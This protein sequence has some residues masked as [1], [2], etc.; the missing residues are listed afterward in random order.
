[1]RAIFFWKTLGFLA[2][3]R[4]LL[5]QRPLGTIYSVNIIN[6]TCRFEGR[7]CGFDINNLFSF[8][9][10][11]SPLTH[12]RKRNSHKNWSA[13]REKLTLIN[14]TLTVFKQYLI[15][16]FNRRRP[17][18]T[19]MAYNMKDEKIF[20]DT[21]AQPRAPK[22]PSSAANWGTRIPARESVETLLRQKRM[23]S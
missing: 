2:I 11:D 17:Q 6:K 19:L 12:R 22:E 21:S 20:Q 23:D 10:L 15:I 7:V 3:C 13:V 8:Y 14:V 16:V 9:F 18:Q 4:Q 5:S 1:M